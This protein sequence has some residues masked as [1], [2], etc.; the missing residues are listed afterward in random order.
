MYTMCNT[1]YTKL[2]TSCYYVLYFQ[3]TTECFMS[4]DIRFCHC[5]S[6]NKGLRECDVNLRFD[7][8]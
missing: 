8:S 4:T 2:H 5:M 6:I 1:Q 3:L 7:A